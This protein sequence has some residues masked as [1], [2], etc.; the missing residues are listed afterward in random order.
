[1]FF[2]LGLV[3]VWNLELLDK[4]RLGCLQSDVVEQCLG[5]SQVKSVEADGF[6]VLQE[7]LQILVFP[8]VFYFG[9]DFFT[10][11]LFFGRRY[12]FRGF[13]CCWATWAM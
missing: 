10:N 12:P 6:V 2:H 11:Q 5:Y 13:C 8:F 9:A 7:N 1:M 4:N 3:G